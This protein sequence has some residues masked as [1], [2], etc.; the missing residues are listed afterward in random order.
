MDIYVLRDGEQTGPFPEEVV[1]SRLAAGEVQADDLAWHAG[2]ED[3]LPIATVLAAQVADSAATA[4]GG[5]PATQ[6]QRAF[7]NFMGINAPP[8][9][10]RQEAALMVNDAVDKDPAR[11]TRWNE[12]RLQLHPELFAEEIE[13]RKEGRAQR[14]FEECQ[15]EGR[16]WFQKV[17]KAH[18]QVLVGHLDVQTPN[19]DANPGNAAAKY[20]FPALAEKFPQLLTAQGRERFT[21]PDAKRAAPKRPAPSPVAKKSRPSTAVRIAFSMARGATYGALILAGIALVQ[22][23][24]AHPQREARPAGT[25]PA[26]TA[27]PPPIANSVPAPEGPAT[28][29][30]VPPVAVAGSEMA[31][32]TAGTDLPVKVETAPPN[33][34]PELIPATPPRNSVVLTKPFTVTLP[35]GRV[36]IPAGTSLRIVQRNGASVSV[37]YL[38]K[39]VTIPATSTDLGTDPAPPGPTT[40]EAERQ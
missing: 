37:L 34:A 8:G 6:R 12:E 2:A 25:K 36:V 22:G 35:Y 23:I 26:A 16:A 30:E 13:A 20:F 40:A 19:W 17:A 27:P 4:G 3:W 29:V 11:L 5:E 24:R 1:R 9:A 21:R 18:C 14:F 38:D 31:P 10:T 32:D 39:A 15:R 33:A 28:P 7:L